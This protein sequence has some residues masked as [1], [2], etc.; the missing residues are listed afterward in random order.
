MQGWK[1]FLSEQSEKLFI[2][3][4][5]G[6][7]YFSQPHLGNLEGTHGVRTLLDYFFLQH[8]TEETGLHGLNE[9]GAALTFLSCAS[10]FN[11]PS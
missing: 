11:F 4:V 8:L 9:L 3:S 10:D 7:G 2:S 1:C 6:G 5:F